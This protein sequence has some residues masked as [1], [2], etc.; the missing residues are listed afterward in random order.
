[1]LKGISQLFG[2]GKDAGHDNGQGLHERNAAMLDAV[3]RSQAIIE[4]ELDG[5][6]VSANENFLQVMGYTLDE[7]KG[8]HHRMFVEPAVSSGSGYS[9]FWKKLNLGEFVAAEFKRI[10]KDGSEVWIQATYTPVLD[11]EGKPYRIVKF[12]TDVTK[13]KVAAADFESQI[14]AI[15]KSQAVIEF[16]LHGTV[17]TANDN[18]LRMVGYQISEVQGRHHRMF[19]DPSYA[20]SGEYGQFWERLRN[21]EYQTGVYERLSK[22]GDSVWIRASYNPVFDLNGRPYKVVK[23]ATDITESKMLQLTVEDALLKTIQ[24]MSAL[25]EGDLTTEF[26]GEYTGKFSD[27]QTNANES[28]QRMNNA[29]TAIRSVASHVSTYSEEIAQNTGNLGQRIVEQA[30]SL[31][32]TAASME[33]ITTTAQESA[34]N[35]S[36]ANE[37]ALSASEKAQKGGDIVLKAVA[38]MKGLSESSEKISEI[39]GVI[40]EIAFQTNL[41]ALNASVEAARA[42][43]QGRGFAVVASEVRD[44]AGRSATAAKE[45]KELIEDSASRVD[46]SRELVNQSGESLNEIVERVEKVT[47]IIGGITVASKEQSLGISSVNS[48][49]T[50]IDQL[51]QN[52]A[53]LVE[54]ATSSSADLNGQAQELAQRVALFKLRGDKHAATTF[55]DASY[56]DNIGHTRAAG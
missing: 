19:V 18:F 24:T 49:I 1:M 29:L 38:A 5:T 56:S 3:S 46:K 8:Q 39:I 32:E 13:Q 16:D 10:K 55:G 34:S 17:I 6:I 47:E 14:V 15:E 33:E 7:I 28:V 26:T 20:N 31:Q 48:A 9:Q 30:A 4:F 23:Y 54:Q 11:S 37:L 41:L 12:A 36:T 21:G 52:N 50:R 45:I 44:L 40:N 51:T 27:L 2:P 25:A 22:S 42:G 53:N 43:S 35:A